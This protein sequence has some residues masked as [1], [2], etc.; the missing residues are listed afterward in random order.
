MSASVEYRLGKGEYGLLCKEV[1]SKNLVWNASTEQ[2]EE[3]E[4][5]LAVFLGFES[6]TTLSEDEAEEIVNNGY[7]L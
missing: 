3:D 6:Y 7:K 4:Y 2:W 1:G 5:A